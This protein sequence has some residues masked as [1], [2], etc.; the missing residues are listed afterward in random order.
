MENEHDRSLGAAAPEKPPLLTIVGP[1]ITLD[2]EGVSPVEREGSSGGFV[3]FGLDSVNGPEAEFKTQTKPINLEQPPPPSPNK[4]AH[5]FEAGDDDLY[6]GSSAH[7]AETEEHNTCPVEQADETDIS[8]DE[9]VKREL[10][11]I[12][13]SNSDMTAKRLSQEKGKGKEKQ[14]SGRIAIQRLPREIILQ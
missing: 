8:E 3:D 14:G 1:D 6:L 13:S 11:A 7:L 12:R 5:S 2:E 10:D 4:S 9:Q